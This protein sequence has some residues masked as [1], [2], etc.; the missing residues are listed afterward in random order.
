MR[1]M[2]VVY[3]QLLKI[4]IKFIRTQILLFCVHSCFCIFSVFGMLYHAPKAQIYTK[5]TK[6]KGKK[7]S[8]TRRF[9]AFVK[10]TF[11]PGLL[12]ELHG[13]FCVPHAHGH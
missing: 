3:S 4:T 8:Q 9:N 12:F 1:F 6:I 5:T 13:R 7:E 10:R 11:K 2:I